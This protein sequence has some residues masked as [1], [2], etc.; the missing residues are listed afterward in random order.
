MQD[1]NPLVSIIVPVYNV[2]KYIDKCLKSII[3]QRYKNIEI[4]LVNDGSTDKSGQI[5]QKYADVDQ[6]IKLFNK[7][8]GG[9]SDAR[10]FALD[11]ATGQYYAF[12]DSDDYIHEDMYATLVELIVR[13]AADIAICGHYVVDREKLISVRNEKQPITYSGKEALNLLLKDEEVNSFA[14]DKL[15]HSSLFANI[16]YPIGRIFE[17]TA[18]TYKLF[19]L[20]NCIVRIDTPLYYYVRRKSSISAAKSFKKDHHNFLGFYERFLFAHTKKLDDVVDDCA[21]MAL[22][23]GM[24]IVDSYAVSKRA[25]EETRVY[26]DTK[27]KISEILNIHKPKNYSKKSLRNKLFLFGFNRNMYLFI[28]NIFHKTRMAK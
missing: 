15:Y 11:R 3:G 10:N 23:H 4:L 13:E 27:K 6:R 26:L 19:N 5:C 8:N 12:V 17:D 20:A 7:P 24:N 28:Y 16:R 21:D 14:W 25:D 2:E 1:K 22:L 18:T 9:L